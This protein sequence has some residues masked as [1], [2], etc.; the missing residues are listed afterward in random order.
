MVSPGQL[1]KSPIKRPLFGSTVPFLSCDPHVDEH[2]HP[3]S[4]SPIPTHKMKL[5][6]SDGVFFPVALEI[7]KQSQTI[8]TMVDDLGIEGESE[9]EFVPL[10]AVSSAVLKKVIEWA[11]QHKDDPPPPPEDDDDKSPAIKNKEFPPWDAEFF[12]EIKKDQAILFDLILAANYL[13]IKRLLDLSCLT[14]TNM[15][16]GKLLYVNTKQSLTVDLFATSR[17]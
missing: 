17:V 13:D 3:P 4:L 9:E 1:L 7:A 12:G 14:V 6:S 11:E 8:K 10:P 2:S 5:Q 15:I 16:K